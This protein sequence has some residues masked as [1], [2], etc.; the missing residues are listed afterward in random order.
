MLKPLIIDSN[1]CIVNNAAGQIS[2]V[3]WEYIDKNKFQPT[4]VCGTEKFNL[5]L[6]N[7]WSKKGKTVLFLPKKE[8]NEE[9]ARHVIFVLRQSL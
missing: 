9:G 1:Y 8:E 2:R 4:I 3:F 5:S 7:L 6:K